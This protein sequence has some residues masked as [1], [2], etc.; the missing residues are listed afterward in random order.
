MSKYIF[1][2]YVKQYSIIRITSTV[3]TNPTTITTTDFLTPIW[4]EGQ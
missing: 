3:I 2:Y 4:R 1:L